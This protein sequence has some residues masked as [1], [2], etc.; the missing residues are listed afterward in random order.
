MTPPRT[1]NKPPHPNLPH[2]PIEWAV[3]AQAV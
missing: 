2:F 1:R 3:Y